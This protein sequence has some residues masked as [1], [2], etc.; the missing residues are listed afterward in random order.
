MGK[1][2][3]FWDKY[4]IEYIDGDGTVPLRSAESFDGEK[5]YVKG[6]EHSRIPGANGV[7]EFI[8]SIL[9]GKDDSFNFSLY[10]DLAD[11]SNFCGISGKA[12]EFHC[13]VDMHIYDAQGNHVGPDENGDIEMNIPGAQ[14]DDIS[15]NKFVFLPIGTSYTIVGNA[16][17]TGVLEVKIND[18]VN[19]HYQ[20]TAYWNE[21]N[22]GSILTV[23]RFNLENN[24]EDQLIQ[25]DE[26]GDGYFESSVAPDAV[27]NEEERQDLI[28]PATDINIS[29]TQIKENEYFSPVTFTLTSEDNAG[30]SGVLKTMYRINEGEWIMYDGS[31]EIADA[32][33]YTIEFYAIDRAGNKEENQK[34]IIMIKDPMMLI[35]ETIKL[36]ESLSRQGTAQSLSNRLKSVEQLVVQYERDKDHSPKD[37]FQKTI[38]RQ[39]ESYLQMLDMYY[40]KG[41]L[42]N[43]IYN[44]IRGNIEAL[45]SFYNLG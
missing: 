41:W 35:A 30:G 9:D 45:V 28:R 5:Y 29:G 20:K 37:V 12:V 32:G 36:A 6:K 21:I 40:Q 4:E 24:I 1:K 33:E 13:P 31:V 38:I 39:L 43:D 23:V 19:S 8:G 25:V 34:I 26:D 2:K 27:L 3:F 16:S 15:G 42:E 44:I 22:I 14:Y 7:K 18:I 11:D 17:S 10:D